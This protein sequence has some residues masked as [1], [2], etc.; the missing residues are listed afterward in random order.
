MRK[1]LFIILLVGI[2]S[3]CA[4]RDEIIYFQNLEE[5]EN[6]EAI[7]HFEPHIEVNDVLDIQVSSFNEEVVQPFRFNINSQS[8]GG[9]NNQSQGPRGYMVE[10]DGTIKFPVL[11]KLDVEGLTRRELEEYLTNELQAYVTD[12]TVRA[13]IVNFRVTVLGETGTSVLQIPNERV[14]MP[15]L[16]A[17]AGDISYGG[18]RENILVIRD[19]NGKKSYGRVDMTDVDVFQNP[20]YF[21]KQNDIVYVEPTYR[22][23]KS[24]GFITSWQGLVSIA[25]TAFSLI[26]LFTR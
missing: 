5:L 12:V 15:E 16:I 6:M 10:V 14:T 4:T 13:R 21:L 18:K 22:T 24:A 9:N 20:Y 3:S 7:E 23:V 19:N 17:M 2:L 11:G 25:T 8:G 26:L 1:S